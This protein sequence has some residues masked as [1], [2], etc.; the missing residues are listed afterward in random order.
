MNEA[1]ELARGWIMEGLSLFVFVDNPN[2]IRTHL[3]FLSRRVKS[4]FKIVKGSL[5]TTV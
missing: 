1:I 5:I 4:R 2:V 3:R